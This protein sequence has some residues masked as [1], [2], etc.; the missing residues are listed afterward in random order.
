M[1]NIIESYYMRNN[2]P[3]ALLRQ[4]IEKIKRNPDIENEFENWIRTGE[5]LHENC[6]NEQNYT[7][8][9]LA[10]LSKFLN[11]EGAFMLLIELRESPQSALGKIAEGFNMI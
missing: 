6:V 11:G 8:E 7:A 9:R 2:I 1:S 3:A 4:K 10:G 5:Y